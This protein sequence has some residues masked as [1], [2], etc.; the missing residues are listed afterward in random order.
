[1]I[2]IRISV[3]LFLFS[4]S[5]TDTL[6]ENEENEIVNLI[7]YD[8][9][10]FQAV[11]YRLPNCQDEFKTYIESLLQDISCEGKQLNTFHADE[12]RNEIQ[13]S[14]LRMIIRKYGLSSLFTEYYLMT[15]N[16]AFMECYQ[17][18][19]VV[20]MR[21]NNYIIY[22]E[23]YTD[24]LLIEKKL[25]IQIYDK[26]GIYMKMSYE[27]SDSLL[28]E[29]YLAKSVCKLKN[30]N[31]GPMIIKYNREKGLDYIYARKGLKINELSSLHKIDC[32]LK[33]YLD[34]RKDVEEI[35]VPQKIVW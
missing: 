2:L 25:H 23:I 18:S 9:H 8:L 11:Y 10:S 17:D 1:M 33:E 15:H 24:S 4:C 29:I 28:H 35:I 5:N 22:P 13:S 14:D 6:K 26:N 34:R 16:K 7:R 20:L 21:N 12:L 31:Y 30:E 3:L 32:F 27:E 19:V